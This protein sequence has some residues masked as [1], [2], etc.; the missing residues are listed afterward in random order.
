M[1]ERLRKIVLDPLYLNSLFLMLSTGV[2]SVSGFAYWW[3]A[4]RLSPSYEVGLS[5][6]LVSSMTYI[7]ILSQLGLNVGILR[8]LAGSKDTA[9]QVSSSLTVVGAAAAVASVLFVLASSRLSPTLSF[10]IGN[11]L[12]SISFIAF[13][14]FAALNVTTESVFIALGTSVNVF[15]KNTLLSILKIA[16]LFVFIPFGAYGILTAWMMAIVIAVMASYLLLP[17]DWRKSLRIRVLRKEVEKMAGYSAGNYC[18]GL[19]GNLALTAIP[20]LLTARDGAQGAA[21]YAIAMSVAALLFS[22]PTSICNTLLAKGAADEQN[23]PTSTAKAIMLISV[24]LIPAVVVVVVFG[25]YA[26]LAFGAEYSEG[27]ASLLSLLALSSVFVSINTV[28]WAVL[29]VKRRVGDILIALGIN[30]F[31][32][33]TLVSLYPTGGLDGVGVAWLLGQGITSMVYVIFVLRHSQARKE[34]LGGAAS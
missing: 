3:L 32:I 12:I 23:L 4:A 11:P 26:L 28:C 14:V 21:H 7:G 8:Y 10:L 27:A 6:T 34:I 30:A 5:A 24:I 18:A 9:G 20:L 1:F 19:L 2:L 25:K 13:M 29:N 17:D 22:I 15:L 33:L 31:S 16:F